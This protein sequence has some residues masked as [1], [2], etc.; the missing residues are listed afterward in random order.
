MNTFIYLVLLS[1][2]IA[3]VIDAFY[4]LTEIARVFP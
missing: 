3:S 2:G 4:I 1:I